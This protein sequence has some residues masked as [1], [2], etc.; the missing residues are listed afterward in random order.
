[1]VGADVR[2]DMFADGFNPDAPRTDEERFRQGTPMYAN[3]SYVNYM[4]SLDPYGSAG[5][6]DESTCYYDNNELRL[7]SSEKSTLGQI[8]VESRSD[9][10][11]H[12]KSSIDDSLSH[13]YYSL[14]CFRL[15]VEWGLCYLQI[16]EFG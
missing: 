14:H 4:S 5:S 13:I 1:M 16:G 11:F 3:D 7:G 12:C 15:H 9:I 8:P 6:Q 10:R 2:S